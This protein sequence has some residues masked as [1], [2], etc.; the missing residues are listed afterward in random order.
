MH[1]L[2]MQANCLLPVEPSRHNRKVAPLQS[3]TFISDGLHCTMS[4]FSCVEEND[5]AELWAQLSAG[6]SAVRSENYI[7]SKRPI[8]VQTLE[9]YQSGDISLGKKNKETL[10]PKKY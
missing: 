6:P 3:D 4:A 7:V 8:T 5:Q 9:G 2:H 10:C 1:D